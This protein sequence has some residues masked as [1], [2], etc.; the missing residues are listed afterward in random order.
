MRGEGWVPPNSP[1]KDPADLVEAGIPPGQEPSMVPITLEREALIS[2]ILLK[3]VSGLACL[4]SLLTG[5]L[6]LSTYKV[7]FQALH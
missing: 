6:S 3:S 5:F 2:R 4:L 7:Y 1:P